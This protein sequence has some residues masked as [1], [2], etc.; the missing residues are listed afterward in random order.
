MATSRMASYCNVKG[1]D[2]A[3]EVNE[4]DRARINSDGELMIIT[5]RR[6]IVTVSGVVIKKGQF[7]TTLTIADG[8]TQLYDVPQPGNLF[9]YPNRYLA[10]TGTML[11]GA[12]NNL[13]SLRGSDAFTQITYSAGYSTFPYDLQLACSLFVR[14]VL[15]KQYNPMGALDVS[16]GN[17]SVQ[18]G[19]RA[20]GLP[21][22]RFVQ[23]GYELLEQGGYV[24][25]AV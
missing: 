10:G 12:S 13:V 23:E 18:F 21:T 1:F 17:Y 3:V 7:T 6:P 22:S 4:E 2:F 14:D 5:R 20:G 24:R 8:A 15:A 9:I 19:P 11:I 16:Q 25:R